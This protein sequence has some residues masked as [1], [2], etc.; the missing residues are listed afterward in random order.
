MQ[1]PVPPDLGQMKDTVMF[2]LTKKQLLFFSIGGLFGLSVFFKTLRLLGSSN[3]AL[4]M[5]VS[6]FPF[7]MLGVYERNGESADKLLMYKLS[8]KRAVKVRPYVSISERESMENERRKEAKILEE[9]IGKSIIYK[10]CKAIYKLKKNT[11]KGWEKVEKWSDRKP[12]K[13][14]KG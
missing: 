6:M 10:C 7:F 1:T 3:A 4:L 14:G 11:L 13:Q 8:H 2:G 9:R 12:Y 5:L